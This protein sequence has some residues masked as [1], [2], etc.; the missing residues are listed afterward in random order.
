MQETEC[1]TRSQEKCDTVEEEQCET[2]EEDECR[3]VDKA[4]ILKTET[5]L[6]LSLFFCSKC[7]LYYITSGEVRAGG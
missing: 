5:A 4:G 2:V 6:S 3:T 1:S 7:D